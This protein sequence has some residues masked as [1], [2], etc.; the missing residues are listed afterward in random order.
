MV[1]PS[2]HAWTS[3]TEGQAPSKQP[4]GE[5]PASS[6]QDGPNE[7]T[8]SSQ[9]PEVGEQEGV[10]AAEKD[11]AAPGLSDAGIE[12]DDD[13]F[14]FLKGINRTNSFPVVP[15]RTNVA[16]SLGPP[17]QEEVEWE[18][19]TNDGADTTQSRPSASFTEIAP[20]DGSGSAADFSIHT[21]TDPA[22]SFDFAG[23]AEVDERYEE[24]LP[25]IQSNR[26]Q[27]ERRFAEK[28]TTEQQLSG[29]VTHSQ[30]ERAKQKP[31]EDLFPDVEEPPDQGAT[32]NL[33]PG[34]E[35]PPNQRATED[36]FPFVEPTSM[37]RSFPPPQRKSTAQVI[38]SLDTDPRDVQPEPATVSS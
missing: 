11:T 17:I 20:F 23:L 24:G 16:S 14:Q 4:S 15:P 37:P 8:S 3:D 26:Q 32:A 18:E 29:D 22:S 9:Q 38:D 10:S 36:L 31:T 35:E 30:V 27:E 21:E 13:P 34:V 5:T 1:E 25:L 2:S 33:F 12:Q 7:A 28:Q 6:Y 19:G